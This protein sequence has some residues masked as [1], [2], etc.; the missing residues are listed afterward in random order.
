M[1]DWGLETALMA[2]N[3]AQAAPFVGYQLWDA[4]G[5]GPGELPGVGDIPSNFDVDAAI[6]E[7]KAARDKQLKGVDAQF[8]D[9]TDVNRANAAIDAQER[10]AQAQNLRG[11][12][13][14]MN[15]AGYSR[16]ARGQF[17]GT[18]HVNDAAGA[19]A[20]FATGSARA[21]AGSATAKSGY[22]TKRAG[23]RQALDTVAT[24]GNQFDDATVRGYLSAMGQ[25][26]SGLEGAGNLYAQFTSDL[27]PYRY[28][29]STAIGEAASAGAGYA[30]L[31]NTRPV[32]RRPRSGQY[33]Y[34]SESD[35]FGGE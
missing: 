17:G 32:P 12:W 28:G 13:D 5:Q 25:T 6:R 3:P 10:M 18:Q 22:L 1:T 23:Q 7:A 11:Y 14:T 16:Q 29:L 35:A 24:R 33:Q 2:V 27:D 30:D 15:N 4:F 31:Y 20:Q 8:G 19:G 26:T 34:Q 9:V 21:R